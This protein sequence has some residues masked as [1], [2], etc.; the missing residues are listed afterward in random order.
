MLKFFKKKEFIYI[1]ILFASLIVGFY[2]NEDSLGGATSDFYSNFERS[3]YLKNNFFNENLDY[4]FLNTRH[5]PFFFLYSSLI[6]SLVHIEKIFRFFHLIIPM[7][8]FF[9]FLKSLKLKFENIDESKLILIS[10]IVFIS[11]T[12]RSYSIWIDSYL[13][14]LLFFII[15]IYNFL[16]FKKYRLT[17]FIFFNIFFLS[18]ASYFMPT[19]S[20]FSIYFFFYFFRDFFL[21]SKNYYILSLIILFNL[22][23]SAPALFY[24]FNVHNFILSTGE[25]GLYEKT[26]SIL[27]ISNK[28]FLSSNIIFFYLIPFLYYF[29][30]SKNFSLINESKY[31]LF[32]LFSIYLLAYTQVNYDN[33]YLNL[34]GGGILYILFDRMLG[35]PLLQITTI[36][37][38]VLLIVFTF[39][40]NFFNILI[41]LILIF[42]NIQLTIYHNYF[43]PLTYILIFT[44]INN[45]KLFNII[46]NNNKNIYSLIIFNSFF[47]VLSLL[48]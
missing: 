30:Q 33:I 43:D 29:F 22:I 44:L 38:F 15:A 32:F 9:Y 21:K 6:L 36:S 39:K 37:L 28:F 26:F 31:F 45:E 16:K 4:S 42:S 20:P 1:A 13:I 5:S 19:F 18:L 34:S 2:L 17:K 11:P 3:E 7:L 23:L 25:W 47:L 27:N 35:L 10:S 14:G 24:V 41:I 12:V 8:I 46:F 48:K 40:K